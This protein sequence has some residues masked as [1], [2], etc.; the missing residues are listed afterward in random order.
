MV[1]SSLL[2]RMLLRSVLINSE[3]FCLLQKILLGSAKF[4]SFLGLYPQITWVGLMDDVTE[5]LAIFLN[6]MVESRHAD[7]CILRAIIL[8]FDPEPNVAE[9]RRVLT[10]ASIAKAENVDYFLA[11]LDA[12]AEGSENIENAISTFTR[13]FRAQKLHAV[14]LHMVGWKTPYWIHARS[15]CWDRQMPKGLVFK[16]FCV[17]KDTCHGDGRLSEFHWPTPRA[18]YEYSHTKVCIRCRFDSELHFF[19]RTFCLGPFFYSF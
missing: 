13:L 3:I 12:F 17:S 9:V 6:M 19:R 4:L 1:N 14:R 7:Y 10:L 5:D 8:M 15:F 16:T 2:R 18:D 11:M